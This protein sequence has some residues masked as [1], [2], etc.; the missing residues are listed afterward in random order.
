MIQIEK[1]FFGRFMKDPEKSLKRL[2]DRRSYL[3]M[4]IIIFKI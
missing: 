2:F 3:G 4:Y 1:F